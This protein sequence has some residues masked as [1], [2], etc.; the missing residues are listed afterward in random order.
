ML[1]PKTGPRGGAETPT[2]PTNLEESGTRG[3]THSKSDTSSL[4]L[5]VLSSVNAQ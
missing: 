1:R 5:V 3:R 4:T 2:P